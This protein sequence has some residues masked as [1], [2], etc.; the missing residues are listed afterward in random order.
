MYAPFM[1]FDPNGMPLADTRFP[2]EAALPRSPVFET[3]RN[4]ARLDVS[5]SF[6]DPTTGER[7]FAI[8]RPVMREGR[9]AYYLAMTF[10]VSAISSVLEQQALPESWIG[11]ILDRQRTLVAR[12]RDDHMHVGEQASTDFIY[13]L[14]RSGGVDGKV[15]SVTRD[16]LK[17]TTFFSHADDSGWVALVGIPRNDLLATALAPL[18]AAALGILLVLAIAI[19]MA[20]AVGRTITRPLAQLDE[21]ASALARGEVFEPPVTGIDET[22]RTARVMAEASVRI[23]RSSQEMAD[24]VRDAVIQA[25]RSHLALL[26]GQ[27]L[28]ALG[29]LTAGISHEFNNLLQS[30]TM[31]LQLAEMLSSNPRAKVFEP[32][33]TG[34]DETDRTARVMADASVRIHL[35]SQEMADRVRDAVIQAERSHLALLQGQKLEALGNLTAGI[36]HEFNNLLQSM[37]MGL[38]LAEMLSSNPRA[39]RA[40]EGCQRSARRA[41]RLTRHLMTFSR[42]RTADPERV[43]LRVLILGMHE[44]LIGALPNRVVLEMKL[45]EGEWPAFVDAVQFELAVLNLAINARDAMAEGGPLIIDLHQCSLPCDNPFNLSPGPYLCIVVED[46]GCGMTPEVQAHIFEPFFTTKPV[47]EGTGLGLAQVYGFARQSGGAVSVYSEVGKGTRISILLPRIEAVGPS[48]PQ[49]SR[50]AV[51]VARE[52]RVL[53]VDDD[54]EVRDAVT[55]M[56]EELGYQV[57][58]APNAA[59]ALDRL[60]DREQ[61]NIDV[62]FSD[63]VMPGPLDGIALAD[64]VHR[65]YPSIRIVLATGYST[66]LMAS[67]GYRVLAKPFSHEALADTL[68]AM[69]DAP[70][71]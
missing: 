21:A 50:S 8:R 19:A 23:H 57:D 47:G 2:Y 17:V 12:T 53:V 3:F 51:R 40:I 49:K 39:K 60:A 46:T 36:S 6:D 71:P 32:P 59:V 56:L 35:S 33:V 11:V 52:A 65:L 58:E 64:E 30:M 42:T 48:E 38:Q 26:Q 29:N 9:A 24:R 5:D 31:G 37:T 68:S 61:P 45:P 27:K 44:L 69:L 70:A 18:G 67:S 14:R 34:I 15:M 7:S 62:L 10:P 43:D 25:E 13:Q 63:I 54:D 16:D 20:V 28:E 66:R 41:T 4:G 22:D 55:A 1:I